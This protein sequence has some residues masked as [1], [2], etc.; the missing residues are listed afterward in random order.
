MKQRET[1]RDKELR[2]IER[3]SYLSLILFPS[4]LLVVGTLEGSKDETDRQTETKSQELKKEIH[5]CR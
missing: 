4:V 5:T 2:I 1:D 3:T